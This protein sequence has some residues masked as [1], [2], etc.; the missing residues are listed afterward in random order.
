MEGLGF[1]GADEPDG[2]FAAGVEEAGKSSQAGGADPGLHLG[3]GGS[4]GGEDS[5]GFSG[6]DPAGLDPGEAFLPWV[7]VHAKMQPS[8]GQFGS[9]SLDGR[10]QPVPGGGIVVLG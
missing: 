3:G 4:A 7:G 2:F 9:V 1:G 10:F 8:F 6:A 5:E